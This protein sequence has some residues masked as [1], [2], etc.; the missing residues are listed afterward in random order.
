MLAIG[1]TW[2]FVTALAVVG[3]LWHTPLDDLGSIALSIGPGR[4]DLPSSMPLQPA[5]P[6]SGVD[7][8]LGSELRGPGR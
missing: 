3:A 2:T 8:R 1:G 6:I 5:A 7:R 4:E